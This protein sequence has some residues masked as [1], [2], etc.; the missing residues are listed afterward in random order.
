MMIGFP[1]WTPIHRYPQRSRQPAN[2]IKT[3]SEPALDAD[4]HFWTRQRSPFAVANPVTFGPCDDACLDW[5]RRRGQSLPKFVW[6]DNTRL[7]LAAHGP[8]TDNSTGG[9]VLMNTLPP[10]FQ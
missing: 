3:E 9:R 6:D 5:T 1:S 4:S 2:F 8:S 10:M 7:T